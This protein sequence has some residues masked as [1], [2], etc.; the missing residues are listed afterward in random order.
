MIGLVSVRV[1]PSIAM[2]GTW[3]AL[4]LLKEGPIAEADWMTNFTLQFTAA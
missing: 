4:L 2:P 3:A 1:A